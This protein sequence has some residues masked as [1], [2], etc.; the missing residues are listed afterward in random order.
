MLVQ[1][2][3][4]RSIPGHPACRNCIQNQGY[5]MDNKGTS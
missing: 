3:N 1:K 4:Q 2:V 5:E